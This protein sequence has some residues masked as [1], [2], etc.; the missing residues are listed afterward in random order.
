MTSKSEIS[1]TPERAGRPPSRIVGSR[2]ASGGWITLAICE[3]VARRHLGR[4]HVADSQQVASDPRQIYK[5]QNSRENRPNRGKN[6]ADRV[7]SRLGRRFL[8]RAP[9]CYHASIRYKQHMCIQTK[10][11]WVNDFDMLARAIRPVLRR[12]APHVFRVG[13]SE[14]QSPI[15]LTAPGRGNPREGRRIPPPRVRRLNFPSDHQ[16]IPSP[17]PTS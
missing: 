16:S 10:W 3:H 4:P 15:R 7:S 1:K 13:G 12:S 11:E 6:G 9:C 5:R 2:Q 17:R 8:S 14:A